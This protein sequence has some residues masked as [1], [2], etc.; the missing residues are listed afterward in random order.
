MSCLIQFYY[1]PKMASTSRVLNGSPF[2]MFFQSLL[3]SFNMQP[4]VD[5]APIAGVAPR[6]QVDDG[7]VAGIFND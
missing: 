6:P 3:P 1:R 2:S 5:G 7:A 4:P